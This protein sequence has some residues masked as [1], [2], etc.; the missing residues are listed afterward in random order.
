MQWH[1]SM[2]KTS[3]RLVKCIYTIYHRARAWHGHGHEV[4]ESRVNPQSI[5]VKCGGAVFVQ[6]DGFAI[7]HEA[8][9]G[10]SIGYS[11][12]HGS[13]GGRSVLMIIDG[14]TS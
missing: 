6:T 7:K 4:E 8:A 3:E 10:D 12:D 2:T 1:G 13:E 9:V 11:S 14:L 5:T